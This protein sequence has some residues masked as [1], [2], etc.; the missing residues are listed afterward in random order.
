MGSRCC[1]G[2]P[3][4]LEG[5]T[6]V[7]RYGFVGNPHAVPVFPTVKLFCRYKNILLF[8]KLNGYDMKS[9]VSSVLRRNSKT[10]LKACIR[11]GLNFHFILTFASVFKHFLQLIINDSAENKLKSNFETSLFDMWSIRQSHCFL[12]IILTVKIP[13]FWDILSVFI[14]FVEC[15]ARAVYLVHP[16]QQEG[17]CSSVM[18]LFEWRLTSCCCGSKQ[19]AQI[20]SK[21]I[22]LERWRKNY[23]CFY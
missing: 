17:M 2:I 20:S 12:P 14:L 19:P 10:H 3:N 7:G 4:F 13:N 23:N 18:G 16:Q 5:G 8:E 15:F 21:E 22:Q 6:Q 11:D 1:F 9:W